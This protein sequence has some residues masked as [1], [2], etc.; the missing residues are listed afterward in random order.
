MLNQC[1]S[2]SIKFSPPVSIADL[3][4]I[5]VDSVHITEHSF[6]SFIEIQAHSA[7]LKRL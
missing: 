1:Y 6:S 5:E 3:I 4:T 2:V 7:S